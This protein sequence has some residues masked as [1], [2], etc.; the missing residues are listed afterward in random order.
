[1]SGEPEPAPGVVAVCGGVKLIGTALLPEFCRSSP[2]LW[3]APESAP[4]QLIV[5]VIPTDPVWVDWSGAGVP[6]HS[7]A[8]QQDVPP[9]LS[10]ALICKFAHPGLSG[11]P[12]VLRSTPWNGPS[13]TFGP[14]IVTVTP[15]DSVPSQEICRH[16]KFPCVAVSLGPPI[17]NPA[18]ESEPPPPPPD[19]GDSSPEPSIDGAS[20]EPVLDELEFASLLEFAAALDVAS[21]AVSCPPQAA[22]SKISKQPIGAKRKV[23]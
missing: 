22:R 14:V 9:P 19:R 1:V 13:A 23:R 7:T 3:Q 20:V 2:T 15:D 6:V 17:G 11:Q 4:A 5:P 18:R 12:A 16:S 8:I 21:P 10:A